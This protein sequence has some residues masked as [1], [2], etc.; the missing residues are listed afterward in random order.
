MKKPHTTRYLTLLGILLGGASVWAAAV[1]PAMNVPEN[2]L[3]TPEKIELG[4]KLFYDPIL[5]KDGTV[6]CSSCHQQKSG[7][8]DAGKAT[9]SGMGGAKGERNSPGLANIGYHPS[10]FWD[11]SSPNLEQQAIGPITSP[12]EMGAEPSELLAKLKAN[13]SYQKAFEEVFGEPISMNTVAKALSSFERALVSSSSPFDRF[14][15][16]DANALN[17]AALRG[18]ELWN[19]ERA[20]C[21]HCHNGPDLTNH[22]AHNIGLALEYSDQ[23]LFKVTGLE[24]D[25]GKFIT[26]SLR[27]VA[28][29]A[30]YMH[31]GSLATLRDVILHYSKGGVQHPNIDNTIQEMQFD[32]ENIADLTAFM[33]SLTDLEFV[34]NPKFGPPR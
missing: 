19:S 5:S 8:A 1:L 12:L 13:A 34:Q 24:E 25:K 27:N 28:L 33:E 14:R 7:F 17:P 10:F 4:R 15:A 3:Q 31:D 22:Q 29:T 11:G 23:G 20:E 32:E 21:W 18:Y 26:P 9:S 16:G 2:N 6:S 30:P